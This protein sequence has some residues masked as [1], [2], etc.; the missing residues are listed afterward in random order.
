MISARC[1]QMSAGRPKKSFFLCS[2]LCGQ[3]SAPSGHLERRRLGVWGSSH[4]RRQFLAS[5]RQFHL[6]LR[7]TLF[8][9]FQRLYR[10]H[11]NW[12]ICKMETRE[13]LPS[14]K[15]SDHR[16]LVLLFSQ[17]VRSGHESLRSH[18]MPDWAQ[19]SLTHRSD[20][21]S[22]MWSRLRLRWS[23]WL[24]QRCTWLQWGVSSA[25]RFSLQLAALGWWLDRLQFRFDRRDSRSDKWNDRFLNKS[26]CRRTGWPL[27]VACWIV[28]GRAASVCWII[29]I[30]WPFELRTRIFCKEFYK[31]WIQILIIQMFCKK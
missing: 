11:P 8:A 1:F 15:F 17:R 31:S 6:L 2:V 9:P 26:T 14:H 7:N 25:S 23:C 30:F 27:R 16:E 10:K 5:R 18:S 20:S 21:E 24:E 13:V 3:Y 29:W 22:G 12:I 28:A 4:R 19:K